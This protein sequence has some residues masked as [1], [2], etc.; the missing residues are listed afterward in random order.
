MVWGLKATKG[1]EKP[2][3]CAEIPVSLQLGSPLGKTW[4]C[5]PVPTPG[6]FPGRP[7]LLQCVHLGLKTWEL[8]E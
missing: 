8:P 5:I 6:A 4:I 2:W 3:T 1:F 7:Q